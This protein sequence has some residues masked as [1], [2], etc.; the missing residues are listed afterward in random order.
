M[1]HRERLDLQILGSLCLMACNLDNTHLEPAKPPFKTLSAE[2]I[3]YVGLAAENRVRVCTLAMP[4]TVTASIPEHAG[5]LESSAAPVLAAQTPECDGFPGEASF[6][7]KGS[8]DAVA[9]TF[10]FQP[11]GPSATELVPMSGVRICAISSTPNV[12]WT[13]EKAP[14]NPE[15]DEP[16]AGT[17]A[18]TEKP[19]RTRV[20]V[21]VALLRPD[22]CSTDPPSNMSPIS[23]AQVSVVLTGAAIETQTSFTTDVN[24]LGVFGFHVPR[25]ATTV[26]AYLMIGGIVT[27]PVTIVRP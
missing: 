19:T 23:F 21:S 22:D 26:T 11:S 27:V 5:E 8:V 18:E 3:Q 24:G 12:A 13:D 16:T 25:V 1:N 15:T 7:W 20:D 4:G 14:L 9:W 2:F 6:L 17:A 10:M